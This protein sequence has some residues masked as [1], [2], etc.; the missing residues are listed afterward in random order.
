MLLKN[1]WFTIYFYA[2]HKITPEHYP[3]AIL[4]IVFAIIYNYLLH[5]RAHTQNWHI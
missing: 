1:K 5:V 4:C 3:D 2:V